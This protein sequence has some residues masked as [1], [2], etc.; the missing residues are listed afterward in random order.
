MI[1]GMTGKP[2]SIKSNAGKGSGQTLMDGSPK[3]LQ[4]PAAPLLACLPLRAR[5][6]LM[7]IDT[8]S[9]SRYTRANSP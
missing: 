5:T 9:Q 7:R 6:S 2:A 4:D 8:P 1:S 3:G